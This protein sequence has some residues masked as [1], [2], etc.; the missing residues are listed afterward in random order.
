MGGRAW[1][2]GI[3]LVLLGK[4][5]AEDGAQDREQVVMRA[6]IDHR[7]Q[8]V[9]EADLNG[10]DDVFDYVGDGSDVERRPGDGRDRR[11]LGGERR[12]L[13]VGRHHGRHEDEGGA[14]PRLDR[15]LA[16]LLDLDERDVECLADPVVGGAGAIEKAGALADR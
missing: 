2:A 10:R 1:I 15:E 14:Q 8:G 12:Q 13:E 5:V 7:R 11:L 16:H 4:H 6:E 3:D 9:A